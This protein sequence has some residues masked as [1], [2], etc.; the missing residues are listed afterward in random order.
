MSVRKATTL[1]HIG[2][3]ANESLVDFDDCSE[4]AHRCKASRAH[5]FAKA[6]AHEPCG[7]KGHA[8]CPV[9]LIAR[10]ALLARA[11]EIGGLKPDM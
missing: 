1:R 10:N 8:K 7:L 11:H 6:M 9:K 5:R 2:L 3:V 4:S